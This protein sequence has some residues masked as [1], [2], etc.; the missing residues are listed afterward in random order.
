MADW[1]RSLSGLRI[2]ME[3]NLE[4]V[5]SRRLVFCSLA[6][7]KLRLFVRSPRIPPH[8]SA[9]LRTLAI[10]IDLSG[11]PKVYQAHFPKAGDR[12]PSSTYSWENMRKSKSLGLI[13]YL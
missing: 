6:W 12:V 9:V 10:P 7:R 11:K 1:N 2:M 13:T 8:I 3:R 5:L 4:A